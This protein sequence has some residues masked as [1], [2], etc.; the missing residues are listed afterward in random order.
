MGHAYKAVGWNRQ[1]R[2]YDLALTAG[3]VLCLAVFGGLT[4]WLRPDATAET[5]ILRSFGATALVLLHVV[6][7][8]GPLCR[9][10]ARFLPLLYNRRHMG[11]AMFV[12]ALGHGTLAFILFH[13]LGV[14]SPFASLF[15]GDTGAVGFAGTPFQP[16]GAIALGILFVMAATSH[17]FWLR[18]LTPRVWK[19]LHMLVYAAYVLVILHV[20]LGVLQSDTSPLLVLVV[21]LGLAW[22]IG[23]HVLAARR[24]S[25]ADRAVGPKAVDDGQWLDAGELDA[26]PEGGAR[27][28]T[29]G[30][31]RVAIFRYDGQLSAVASVCR[32]QGG[33]LGEGRVI[34]G[35]IVC[36]WHGYQ[37]RPEDGCSP[38]P[39]TEKVATYR[40]RV[41]ADRV[42]V[43]ARALPAGTKVEPAPA[44]RQ[45]A[46]RAD[47]ELYVGYQPHAAPRQARFTLLAALAVA[48][49]AVLAVTV[50]AANQRELKDSRFEFGVEREFRGVIED[51]PYP[52][53]RVAR[54][55]TVASEQSTSAYMLVAP[56]KFGADEVVAPFVGKGV[57]LR[58]SLVHQGGRTLIEVVPSSLQP[59]EVRVERPLSEA[60]GEFTLRG[61]IVDSKCHLGVMNPGERRTHRACAKL[62]I[63]GGIPPILW[64]EDGR[65]AVRRLLLVDTQG[66]AVNE[67]VID[68]VGDPVEITGNV[69]RVDDLLVLRADPTTYRR[70]TAAPAD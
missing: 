64:V 16:L 44:V 8:V 27:T 47:R 61:E 24:E 35:C 43:C 57:S 1:K 17:D 36:P 67:R 3:I 45:P 9:I 4:L 53:L 51:A 60:L 23:L 20:A 37:Y 18:N 56:G 42:H 34:D 5:L 32:H 12:L 39:F 7:S 41:V 29:V 26:I 63:R 59:A 70:V 69:E 11:V 33:P 38:A 6:L 68:L 28:V 50:L 2:V 46:V 65:G 62:C 30:G 31:E 15:V 55:G 13:T 21:A 48:S 40:V 22:L 49:V 14:L 19:T 10:H 54:P 52:L 58:G 66:Q 25:R